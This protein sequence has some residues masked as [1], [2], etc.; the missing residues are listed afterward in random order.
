MNENINNLLS[1]YRETEKCLN[2]GLEW[3]LYTNNKPCPRILKSVH[4]Q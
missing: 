3:Q 4:K 2:Q 1:E